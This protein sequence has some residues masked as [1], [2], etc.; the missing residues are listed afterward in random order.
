MNLCGSPLLGPFGGFA[1]LP[2]LYFLQ[3]S[4]EHSAFIFFSR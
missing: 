1:Y 2:E 3:Q 4:F